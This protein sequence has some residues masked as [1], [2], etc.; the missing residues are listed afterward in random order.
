MAVA[1]VNKLPLAACE[2]L[3]GCQEVTE[4]AWLGQ[5]K[6]C[7]EGLLAHSGISTAEGHR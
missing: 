7:W 5:R 4:L 6:A 1:F 3:L 2:V